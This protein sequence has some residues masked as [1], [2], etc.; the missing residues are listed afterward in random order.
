[1]DV[2]DHIL[3]DNWIYGMNSYFNTTLDD[4]SNMILNFDLSIFTSK[5]TVPP[6]VQHVLVSVV[7]NKS[8]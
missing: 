6:K 2:I 4:L 1:M 7:F 3:R 5:D 8:V